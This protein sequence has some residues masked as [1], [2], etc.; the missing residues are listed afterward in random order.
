MKFLLDAAP[1]V[2]TQGLG[3]LGIL[4]DA[5]HGLGESDSAFGI[6]L[7]RHSQKTSSAACNA[8]CMSNSRG[9]PME[10]APD[11]LVIAAK[12]TFGLRSP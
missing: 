2:N 9:R 1:G 12:A 10:L 11:V 5:F 3:E 8:A 4:Q 7:T 6:G